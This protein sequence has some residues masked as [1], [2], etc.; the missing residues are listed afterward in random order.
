MGE[1]M[2]RRWLVWGVWGVA[3]GWGGLGLVWAA[4]EQHLVRPATPLVVA[5]EEGDV[6]LVVYNLENYL[7]MERWVDGVRLE[8]QPKPEAAVE[9]VVRNLLALAPDILGV[10]EIGT[11]E[12]LDDLGGRLAAGGLELP[13]RTLAVAAD[14]VRRLGLLSRYPVV[15]TDHQGGLSYEVGEVVLPFQRGIMDASV[16]IGEGDVLRLLGVHLK[17]KRDVPEADQA[18]MRR[19]EGE[20]LRRHIDG[21]LAGEPGVQLLVFGDFNDY[22]NEPA[23]RAVR[24]AGGEAGGELRAVALA[25]MDGQEWTHYWS[26]MSLYSRIDFVLH[27][28]AMG[29]RVVGERSFLYGP[30]DFADA[31]DHRAMVVR[32]R[33]GAR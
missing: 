21:I 28:S 22:W 29:R 11:M 14:P 26:F 20:L 7:K 13:H 10:C 33:G 9:K 31:S 6:T 30:A 16:E 5:A 3:V 2:L 25:D 24:G 17:S 1:M 4:G 15:A 27:S 18:E 32:I 23:M 8:G 12:D 19:H